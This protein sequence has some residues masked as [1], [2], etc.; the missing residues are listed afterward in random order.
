[1]KSIIRQ[2]KADH[3]HFVRLLD[4]MEAQAYSMQQL[5]NQALEFKAICGALAYLN[6]YPNKSHH[7]VEQDMFAKIMEK[8]SKYNAMIK[9]IDM[10][11]RIIEEQTATMMAL[12]KHDT[13]AHDANN[14]QLTDA[15][16]KYIEL[17]RRHLIDE[18]DVLFP[19]TLEVLSLDDLHFIATK[20]MGH[21]DPLFDKSVDSEFE[22]LLVKLTDRQLRLAASQPTKNASLQ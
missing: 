11:H 13:S 18:E 2:L 7:P 21:K 10:E 3:S 8:T 14:S 22:S 6:Y 12:I 16:F 9:I 4:M 19:L 17:Q 15:I 5:N 1:M 20:Y